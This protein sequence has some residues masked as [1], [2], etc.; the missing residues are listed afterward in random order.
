MAIPSKKILILDV[1][2]TIRNKGN[3]F[4]DGNKCH[5]IGYKS[6][7][8]EQPHHVFS[9]T[10]EFDVEFLQNLVDSHDYLCA[11]NA[12]FDMAWLEHL[13]VKV[14]MVRIW[15][16]QYAEFI[17][18]SQLNA[19]PSLDQTLEKYG[20]EKK[21]DVIKEKYWNNGIDTIDIPRDDMVQ[22]LYG[23]VNKE[24]QVLKI[25]LNLFREKERSKWRLFQ[26]HMEDQHVLRT[27]ERNGLLFDIAKA[28]TAEK[29]AED[30]I[31]ECEVALM[32]GYQNI[33]INFDSND[34][35]SAYLYG[36]TISEDVRIPIGVYK[37]GQKLGQIRHKIVTYEHQLPR[38]IE[39]L[40][41][42]E[43]K[44]DGT[45]STNEFV[46]R[47]LK[48]TKG[49]KERI[50]L[51]NKRAKW[52]KLRGTYYKGYAKKILEMGWSNDLLHS[53]LNQ[54]VAVTGRLSSTNPNQ[55]NIP[56]EV[57]KL[58]VSRYD[59]SC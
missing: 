56:D 42:S 53:S 30:A 32:E 25:Q 5:Y 45:W 52:E 6:L 10:G 51:L 17:F 50:S 58:I 16:L 12:K 28:G 59:R 7:G 57:R 41:K 34:H 47:Q 20:L 35:V 1:E 49:A 55:Q 33:P 19:Y 22:Y 54:C 18:S 38:I 23:D 40:P 15:D 14:G 44:K 39:P 2:T 11:F 48:G 27:M 24:E 21:I 31:K 46:L 29:E 37:S 9:A 43:L 36:G 26:L 4:T 8:E 13:G 3:V